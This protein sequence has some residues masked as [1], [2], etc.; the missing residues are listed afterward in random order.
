MASDCVRGRFTNVTSVTPRFVV[1]FVFLLG[2]AA[3]FLNTPRICICICLHFVHISTFSNVFE[4]F[5][6]RFIER[7]RGLCFV[8]KEEIMKI[9]QP[10]TISTRPISFGIRARKHLTG[11]CEPC[12]IERHA[13]NHRDISVITF[14]TAQLEAVWH[15]SV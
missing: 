6:H 13:K 4:S 7:H 15:V 11:E 8:G 5:S 12:Q 10:L 9:T 2:W 3:N 14:A 1:K